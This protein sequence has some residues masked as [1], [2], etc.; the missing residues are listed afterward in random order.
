MN[1]MALRVKAN[2]FGMMCKKQVL[3]P[4]QAVAGTDKQ[5]GHILTR[6]HPSRFLPLFFGLNLTVW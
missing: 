1:K 5:N 2:S 4:L 3:A 6:E